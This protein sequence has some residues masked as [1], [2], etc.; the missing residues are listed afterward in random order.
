MQ[1]IY[2]AW[3]SNLRLDNTWKTICKVQQMVEIKHKTLNELYN[4]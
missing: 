2:A 1:K 3:I 4:S